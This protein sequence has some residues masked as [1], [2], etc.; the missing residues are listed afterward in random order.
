MNK[1]HKILFKTAL[2]KTQQAIDLLEASL[3][4]LTTFNSEL[5]YTPE[6]REPYDALTARFVRAVEVSLSL[7]RSIEKLEYSE[8]SDTLRDLLHH[9]EK[10]ELVSETNIW[11]EMRDIRNR[12]VHDYLPEQL[13]KIYDDIQNNFGIELITFRELA[14]SRHKQSARE[15]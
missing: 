1:S 11:M 7:M 2:R 4:K 9:M 3:S 14:I 10:L 8:Q 13:K 12:V 15:G 6:E 5:E